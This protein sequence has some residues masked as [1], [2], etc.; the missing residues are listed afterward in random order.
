MN[1][2][3]LATFCAIAETGSL[4]AAARRLRITSAA[5]GEQMQTLEKILGSRLVARQGRRVVPTEAGHAVLPA[6]R[7]ILAKIEDLRQL[8]QAGQLRGLLRVGAISTALVTVVPPALQS[9]AQE[10]PEIELKVIPGTSAQLYQ[11]LEEGEIDCAITVQPRF[12]LPKRMGWHPIRSEPLV[13]V[14]PADLAGSDARTLLM[15]APFIRI[16]RTAWSGHIITSFL[17]DQ[18]LEPEELFEMDA[19][20]AIIILIAS[21]LG[22]SL[23]PD[24]GIVAPAGRS[25][26]KLPIGDPRYDRKLGLI[27]LAGAREALIRVF[28]AALSAA[29]QAGPSWV[30]S[31]L[32]T[33][34]RRCG[35]TGRRADGPAND[36]KSG[37]Q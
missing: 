17:R 22:V 36:A 25:I 31:E 13:L 14:T 28:A 23:L 33:S 15:A 10:H 32:T 29:A 8:A 9:M 6:A 18:R 12:R 27:G 35:D 16:D 7:A 24:W 2:R 1:T 19:Q 11:Q 5:A 37:T 34:G 4:A 20:E 3:F 26:R 30:E 21:G